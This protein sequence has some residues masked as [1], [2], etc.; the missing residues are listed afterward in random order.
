MTKNKGIRPGFDVYFPTAEYAIV[1]RYLINHP[2]ARPIELQKY[3]KI[4]RNEF[5]VKIRRM[6]EIGLVYQI[7]RGIYSI[8]SFGRKV[9]IAYDKYKEA[10]RE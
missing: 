6:H 5:G 9:L 10:M 1:L 7:D 8:T 4:N 2:T 3:A